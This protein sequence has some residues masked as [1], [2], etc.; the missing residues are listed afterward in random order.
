MQAYKFMLTLVTI[1][2]VS[3]CS[4]RLTTAGSNVITS[5]EKLDGNYEPLGVIYAF[6]G[7]GCGLWGTSGSFESAEA[8][9]R[10]QAAERGAA[11]VHITD[12]KTPVST[13]TCAAHRYDITGDA[14]RL[15]SSE[16][17]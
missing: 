17:P 13:G 7:D 14:Y 3:A 4:E 1:F 10:N 9:I 15:I 11:Y 2:F 6:D 5:M 12:L 8:K 16:E